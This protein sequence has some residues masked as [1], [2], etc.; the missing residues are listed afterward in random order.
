[1]RT[2]IPVSCPSDLLVV[3]LMRLLAASAANQSASL[4]RLQLDAD[5]GAQSLLTGLEPPDHPG[6][7]RFP[8]DCP[9]GDPCL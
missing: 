1:L 7:I 4:L 5:L 3:D 6:L 9:G 8:L 2:A